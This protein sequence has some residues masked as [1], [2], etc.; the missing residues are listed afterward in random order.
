MSKMDN[1]RALREARYEQDK[2]ARTAAPSTS[3]R[4]SPSTSPS[5]SPGRA[6]GSAPAA[7]KAAPRRAPAAAPTAD[8]GSTPPAESAC[9]HRAISGR[10]CTRPAGHAEKNHRYA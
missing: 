5:T 2:A 6:S 4:T 3:T 8:S 7:R 1:L 9:G 10:T